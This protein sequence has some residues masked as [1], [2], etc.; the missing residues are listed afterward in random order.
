M[1]NTKKILISAPFGYSIKNFLFS[2]F[3]QSE[4]VQNSQIYILTPTPAVYEEYFKKQ[5]IKNV[6][7]IGFGFGKIKFSRTFSLAWQ[8]Y[9]NRFLDI[10]HSS[11]QKVKWQ[12]LQEQSPILYMVKK[13]AVFFSLITP[14]FFIKRWLYAVTPDTDLNLP[15]ELDTWLS[16]APS[17]DFDLLVYKQLQKSHKKIEKI[18]FVHSWD[19]ISSKGSLIC[20]YQKILVWGRLMKQEIVEKLRIP[21]SR[22]IEVGMPQYDIWR[23]MNFHKP[24]KKYFLY[25]TGHPETVPGEKRYVVDV[26]RLMKKSYKDHQLILRVHP[27]DNIKNYHDM[28]ADYPFLQ[29]E[30]PGKRTDAT[31]D[32]WSPEEKDMLHF[33]ELLYGADAVINIASTLILDASYFNTPVICLDYDKGQRLSESISRFYKYEHLQRLLAKEGVYFCRDQAELLPVISAAVANH[34]LEEIQKTMYSGHDGYKDGLAGKR[35]GDSLR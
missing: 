34:P 29:V 23:G 2:S 3:W 21:S 18:A 8:I 14:E 10:T 16:L 11:T 6:E 22:V 28:I 20:D 33:G 15:K 26:L 32:K 24:K 1:K 13:I 25:T 4:Q 19:N 9:K 7:V 30:D 5:A 35:L 12:V 27:N 17:F 31:Y